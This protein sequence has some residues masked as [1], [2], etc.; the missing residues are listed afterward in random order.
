MTE[1]KMKGSRIFPIRKFYDLE[2]IKKLIYRNEI[3]YGF[4]S[5]VYWLYEYKFEW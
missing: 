4:L 2:P 5:D 1:K 3:D